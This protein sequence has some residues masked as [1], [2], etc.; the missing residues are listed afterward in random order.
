MSQVLKKF[1]TGTRLVADE[2]GNRFKI[3]GG[4]T[5]HETVISPWTDEGEWEDIW[6][7]MLTC[8]IANGD[9]EKISESVEKF[10]DYECALDYQSDVIKLWNVLW[11]DE[12]IW[13]EEKA[14]LLVRCGY[15]QDDADIKIRE[16]VNVKKR[17]LEEYF[18][19]EQKDKNSDEQGCEEESV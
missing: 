18:N 7:D 9:I 5:D 3:R 2:W 8:I 6:D 17:E 11:K 19:F 4:W 16:S 1:K 13:G 14:S 10:Y 15:K 12:F